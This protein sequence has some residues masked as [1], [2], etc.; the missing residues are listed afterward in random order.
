MAGYIVGGAVI[1]GISGYVGA[2]IAA[3]GGF[4]ANTASIMAS[5]YFNS[6]GMTMLSGGMIQPSVSFGF[7][8]LNLVTGEFSY[9]GK[10]GNSALQNTGYILGLLSNISDITVGLDNA[11]KGK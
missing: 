3:E 7:G 11:N 2:S 4:M 10:K 1:G 6:M 5:S 9:L 8:S